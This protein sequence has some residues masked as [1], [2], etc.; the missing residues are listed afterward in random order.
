MRAFEMIAF[1][2]DASNDGIQKGIKRRRGVKIG[3]AIKM[4]LGTLS[5]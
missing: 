3:R 4:V 2:G 1:N 5:K